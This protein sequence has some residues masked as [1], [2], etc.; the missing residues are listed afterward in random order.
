MAKRLRGWELE[1]ESGRTQKPRASKALEKAQGP[2]VESVLANKLLH[3]WAKGTL[4]ATLLRDLA[5][6]ALQVGA[7]HEDLVA[8]AQTGNW[9]AQPGNCHKQILH[10]FCANVKICD[11]YEVEVPCI[12]PKTSKPALEKASI[13]LPHLMFSKLR[14]KLP[15]TFLQSVQLWKRQLGRFLERGGKVTG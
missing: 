7:S 10:H 8:L 13:F 2:V 15:S 1:Y 9:G 12:D 14:G 5:D 3:L 11:G 6:C 4:S